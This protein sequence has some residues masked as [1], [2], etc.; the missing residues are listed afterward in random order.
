MDEQNKLCVLLF[1]EMSL[2]TNL[3][4]NA[5]LDVIEGYENFGPLGEGTQ[6]ANSALVFMV[7]GLCAKWKQP[8]GYFLSHNAAPAEKLKALVTS[9][10]DKLTA[11]GLNV[12]VDL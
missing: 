3:T 4:Y 5:S 2:K 12:S 1:D 7:K 8:I 10:V 9:A 11:I 6:T